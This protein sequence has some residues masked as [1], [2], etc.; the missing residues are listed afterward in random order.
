MAALT[1]KVVQ[2]LKVKVRK[3]K[4]THQLLYMPNWNEQPICH[5]FQDNASFAFDDVTLTSKE[6]Q[7]VKVKVANERPHTSYYI[8]PIGT[9]SLTVTVFEIYASEVCKSGKTGGVA[10]VRV[11]FEGEDRTSSR[12][13]LAE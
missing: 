7:I 4:A 3:R 9:N 1:S 11:D 5:R 2:I 12:C 10:R 6:G 8:F 13:N